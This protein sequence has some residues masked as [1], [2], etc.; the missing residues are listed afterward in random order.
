MTGLT[1]SDYR[2]DVVVIGAGIL[3]V[4]IAISAARRGFRVLVVDENSTAGFGS[5][6]ASAG[7]IRI[8]AGEV[9]GSALAL[10]SVRSWQSWRDFAEVPL[11]QAA[12]RFEQCGTYILD[13]ASGTLD[14]FASVMTEARVHFEDIDGD[15]LAKAIP[16]ADTSRFGP[17]AAL[18]SEAFWREPRGRIERAL[19][20]PESGYVADPA[21][22]AQN[23][24]MLAKRL[25]VRFVMQKRVIRSSDTRG[26]R[27]ELELAG[28]ERI[29]SEIVVNAAGPGS[30]QLNSI[31][32]VG[33]DFR[34]GQRLVRQELHHVEVPHFVGNAAHIVDGDLGI[35]FRP[36]GVNAFLVG[37][38]GDRVD[39]EEIAA[40]AEDFVPYP[41]R[42]V[43]FRHTGRAA[44]RIPGVVLS[45]KPRGVVGLYDVTDDWLPIFDRSDR[46][47]VF[48]A[49]GTSGN[50]FKTAPVV[51]ELMLDLI[52]ASING[53]DP[54]VIPV[55]SRLP[56]TG[57]EVDMQVFSRLRTPRAG[58][59][60]G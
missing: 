31:L 40:S 10:E 42:D 15:E 12:I 45:P 3:G 16:W 46:R 11:G 54:D 28:G 6:S 19:H 48:V 29:E 37:A 50:Q 27:I 41:T 18:E 52:E 25:G 51:G 60:R 53:R 39:D 14:S 4:T 32:G 2:A 47:G 20:T 38:S 1:G 34:V 24:A 56:R 58:G 21:L 33:G 9:D 36:E 59:S 35:N 7:I 57:R 13:D 22:A 44:R 17:P 55:L 49:I 30:I 23:L 8:H 26:D 43:W 5:T